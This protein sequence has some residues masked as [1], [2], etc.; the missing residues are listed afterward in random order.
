MKNKEIR[1]EGGLQSSLG[2]RGEA[3]V[4]Q[5]FRYTERMK[6]ERLVIKIYLAKVESKKERGRTRRRRM[7]GVKGCLNMNV[8]E[9]TIQKARVR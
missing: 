5:W 2:E 6:G 4:L 7:D 8:K 3:G 9:L 1:S